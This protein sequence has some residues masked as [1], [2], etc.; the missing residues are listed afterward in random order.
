MEIREFKRIITATDTETIVENI[1]LARGCEKLDA[2][3]ETGLFDRISRRFSIGEDDITVVGSAKLGFSI[4][5]GSR[6][7]PFNDDSDIDVAIAN[8]GLFEKVWTEVQ[9][10]VD[11]GAFWAEQ[12]EFFS[13]LKSGWIRP[14]KLPSGRAFDFSFEWWKFFNNIS[15]NNEFGPHKIRAGIYLNKYFL[16]RYQRICIDQ[17][18]ES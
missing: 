15:S 13:Y 3:A 9:R 8:P 2:A 12:E 18:K 10:F 14:D 16:L 7:R 5:P 11:G 6:Y 17:L 1:I 4:K